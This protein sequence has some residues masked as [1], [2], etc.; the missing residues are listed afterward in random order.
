MR[1]ICITSERL[2][3]YHSRVL[4]SGMDIEQYQRNP[5][6]LYM[7]E[8]GQVIGYMK[9][10]KVEEDGTITG[11]PVFDCATDLSKRC[12]AQYEFGSLRMASVGID[13]LE[14][15]E[16]P[17]LLV[18]GQT[19]PTITK[20]K[21]FEVS[22][23]DIGANDDAIRLHRDGKCITLG[24]E[25]ECLLPLININLHKQEK[26]METKDFALML[27]L[28]ETATEKEIQETVATMAKRAQQA[29]ALQKQVE[30]MQEQN[31][32]VLV[33]AA[34]GEKRITAD[35]KNHFLELGKKLGITEFKS[36]LDAM[37]VQ[38]K[39]SEMIGHENP[40]QPTEYKKLSDV[41]T[42]ELL[43]L[44]K[45]QPELYRKLYKAE[46]GFECEMED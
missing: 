44:R 19:R 21:L 13:I 36:L 7:H 20:S 35:K 28:A 17:S 32:L 37:P 31:I 6:L 25:D 8:R 30:Q 15:S 33:D 11:E 16:E 46:Y 24:K 39:L 41:P 10:L 23:V 45:E 9:D 3:C 1:R 12:K 26:K 5:V 40:N 14:M 34:I 4:T 38:K 29:A 2:N 43:K 18:P 22:M 27:G 42:A